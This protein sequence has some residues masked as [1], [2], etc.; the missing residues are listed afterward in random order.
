MDWTVPLSTLVGAFVGVGST[1]LADLVRSRRDR[2]HQLVT[3][4][5]QVYAQ[6]LDALT[7][8]DGELQ[9]LAVSQS[10]PVDELDTRTAWRKYSLLALRYE[11]ELVAPESVA[12]LPMPP[13]GLF[14]IC[15]IDQRNQAEGVG[16]PCSLEW[17]A[18]H[19]PNSPTAC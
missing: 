14:G 11:V 7:K 13:T 4:R 16:T 15:V 6:Y 9:M 2:I 10:T 19:L 1:P 3:V 17:E 12:R 5:R 18:V 8:T